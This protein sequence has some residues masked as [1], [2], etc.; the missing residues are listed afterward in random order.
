MDATSQ[1]GSSLRIAVAHPAVKP[2]TFTKAHMDR[3]REVVL[4]MHNGIMPTQVADG[5]IIIRGSGKGRLMDGLAGALRGKSIHQEHSRRITSL[6]KKHRAEVLLAEYGYTAM[7]V[8]DACMAAGIPLVAHFFGKDA[9]GH[10]YLAR[11]GNY[12]LLFER[13]SAIVVVS[14]SME[15][16]LR[17]LGA[18][19]EKL[20]YIC[21]G[22][23]VDMFHAAAPAAAGQHFL[24]VG[25]FV[26]KKAPHLTILAFNEVLRSRPAARLTMVGNGRVWETCQQMVKAMGLGEQVDL[27]G[28][29][30]PQEILALK[31]R[32]RAFVQHSV[33][34]NDGDSEGTPVAIQEAMASGLPIISTRHAGILDV[35]EHG[36]HG[37]LCEPFDIKGMAGDM[38]R[39][40]DDPELA[41]TMG[42][43]GRERALQ[44]FPV[45]QQV[46]RLQD[47]LR[48]AARGE[49][50]H[51]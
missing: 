4:V 2:E 22:V 44:D 51:A 40:I 10:E 30:T 28:V 31:R 43:Q 18:P 23:D 49:P 9:H 25:R 24:A 14:R 42:S 39:L 32:S 20:V 45:D 15:E 13:A 11:Y 3:L 16:H 34:A 36:R 12:K 26:E 48:R 27:C 1:I 46:A 7:E 8:S 19:P 21:C 38:I 50:I 35:V 33:L 41:R 6:L 17:A 29:K 5:D 37:L 47:V